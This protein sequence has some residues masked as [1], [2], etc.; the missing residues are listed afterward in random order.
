M[1]SGCVPVDGENRREATDQMQ[2]EWMFGTKLMMA[3]AG[4]GFFLELQ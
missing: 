3:G 4:D 1:D 2:T